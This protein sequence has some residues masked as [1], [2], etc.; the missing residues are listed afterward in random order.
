MGNICSCFHKLVSS[1]NDIIK[2]HNIFIWLKINPLYISISQED[3]Q[4]HLSNGSMR[5]FVLIIF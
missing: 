2:T 5:K 3:H 1:I 4:V